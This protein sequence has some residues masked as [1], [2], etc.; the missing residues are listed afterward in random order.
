M[1]TRRYAFAKP[2]VRERLA[3]LAAE[4]APVEQRLIVKAQFQFFRGLY[5]DGLL[6]KLSGPPQGEISL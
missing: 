2:A 5:E 4:L 3:G 6:G 1:R